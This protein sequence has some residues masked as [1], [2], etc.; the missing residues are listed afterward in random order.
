MCSTSRQGTTV[1]SWETSL[2]FR[3]I[4][5]ARMPTPTQDGSE[6]PFGPRC[7]LGQQ[8]NLAPARCLVI[9]H[10][11]IS[12]VA[13][14]VNYIASR[15]ITR[16][17]PPGLTGPNGRRA[18][19]RAAESLLFDPATTLA[20]VRLALQVTTREGESKKCE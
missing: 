2:M 15:Y 19:G 5:S 16:A 20:T 14:L 18:C 12:D 1:G 7:E 3:C 13:T 8:K 6:Q 17:C 9:S 10:Y 11:D 4:F